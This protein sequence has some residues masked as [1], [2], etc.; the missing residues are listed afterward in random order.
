MLRAYAGQD[1]RHKFDGHCLV[2]VYQ[3][4]SLLSKHLGILCL[5]SVTQVAS[6]NGVNCKVYIHVSTLLS[7]T[8]IF[9]LKLGLSKKGFNMESIMV[10]N[11]GTVSILY[12]HY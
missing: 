9:R 11:V 5:M 4:I 12:T 3:P 2:E 8:F 10:N 6:Q 1:T 7:L